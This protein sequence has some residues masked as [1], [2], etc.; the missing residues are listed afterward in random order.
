MDPLPLST[1]LILDCLLCHNR[2]VPGGYFF[3]L[4]QLTQ[5]QVLS[6][7]GSGRESCFF[8][9]GT[10]LSTLIR[11]GGVASLASASCSSHWD[12]GAFLFLQHFSSSWCWDTS[13][14]TQRFP[15]ALWLLSSKYPDI[16][17]L[18]GWLSWHV[19][20]QDFAN[21]VP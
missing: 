17:L 6:L 2:F 10:L 18:H 1:T 21:K 12:T 14:P 9:L 19:R 3:F 15:V 11:D 20:W 5:Y 16:A 7:E 13:P 4:C 8:F